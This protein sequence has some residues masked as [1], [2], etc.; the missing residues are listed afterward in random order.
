[1][2]KPDQ[3][4]T[5]RLDANGSVP[6]ALALL[7]EP[8]LRLLDRHPMDLRGASGEVRMNI[9]AAVP[10][11][12]DLKA[13]DVTI[14][15]AG[16]LSK[17]HLT[18]IVSGHDLDDGSFS[19]D[20]DTNHL[21]LKGTGRVA[22]IPATIEGMLDF[23]TGPSSQLTQRYALNGRATGAALADAG[24]DTAGALTGD[25]GL[26]VVLNEYRSGDGEL[27]ADADLAQAGLSV[28]PLGWRKPV[29]GAARASL[30][31]NLTKDKLTGIDRIAID[32]PGM[33]V[34][35]GATV[36][37][38]RLDTV[39]LDRFALGRTDVKGTIRLA[40]DG[41]I[42]IDVTGPALDVSAKVL[43]KPLKRDPAALE[44]AGPK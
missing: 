41:P 42:G 20:I 38:G 11:T 13:D 17:T 21:S 5:I 33:Q 28:S 10:L 44:P 36:F 8:R 31:L 4:A 23:R 39:R 43:E 9:Q 29:G 22:G 2:S 40:R 27:T 34:R 1:M 25:V 24:L 16:T 30:R 3:L 15:G 37:D 19:L 35:G 7:K 26:N 6:S 32:G 14:H 12:R 18:G